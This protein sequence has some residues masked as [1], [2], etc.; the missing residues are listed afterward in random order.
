MLDCR[1]GATV[2][3]TT[4]L[5]IDIHVIA[6]I[7][8]QEDYQTFV[9]GFRDMFASINSYLADPVITIDNVNY[10][11]EVFCV[12]ADYKV[13]IQLWKTIT[14]FSLQLMLL[15][16]G[17]QAAASTEFACVWCTVHKDDRWEMQVKYRL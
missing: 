2:F 9:D 8:G 12:C 16:M 13:C 14:A 15:I 7:R 6:A 17:L 3:F 11:L 4:D 5:D 1:H 10:T